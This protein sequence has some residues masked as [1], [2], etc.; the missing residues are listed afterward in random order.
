MKFRK[1][2]ENEFLHIG[3]IP[4]NVLKHFIKDWSTGDREAIDIALKEYDKDASINNERGLFITSC[5]KQW[6]LDH[7]YREVTLE[8]LRTDISPKNQTLK[9]HH[10][11]QCPLVELTWQGC[12][13]G[14]I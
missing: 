14:G 7:G 3:S 9:I 13:C 6:Y 11:C 4:F 2:K 10:T 8:D 5:H 12:K 1:L